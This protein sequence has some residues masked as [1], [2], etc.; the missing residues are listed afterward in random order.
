MQFLDPLPDGIF[1]TALQ[2]ADVL[3]LNE[4]PEIAEMC[5]PSKLTSYFA[6]GRPVVAA[7]SDRSAGTSEVTVSGS[8]VSAVP[9]D[10]VALLD[11]VLAVVADETEALAM[12][13]R[14]QLFARDAAG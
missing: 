5:V 4:R 10:P 9:G 8:G 1:E 11:A 3:V 14:G 12:G 7:S 13:L 2:A 6:A